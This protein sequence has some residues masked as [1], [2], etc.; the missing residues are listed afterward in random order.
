MNMIARHE[1]WRKEYRGSRY[2]EFLSQEE[3]ETRAKDV[4]C[5]LMILS[6]KGQISLREM[7]RAGE[8]W[9]VIWTHLLEEFVIRYGPYPNG[10]TNGFIKDADVVVPS[11]PQPLRSKVAIDV[12]GGA[13]NGQLYKFSRMEFLEDSYKFGRFRI[14][15]ASAYNDPSLNNAVRDDELSFVVSTRGEKIL[16]NYNNEAMQSYGRVD[17]K[18]TSNTNY[19][20]ACFATNYTYR[21]Y[22]D[23]KANGCL[24]I[25]DARRF[26]A[27]LLEAVSAQL[28]DYRCFASSVRYIDPLNSKPGDVDVF[29]AKH[30]RFSYQNEYRAVWVP[31]TDI[32]VLEPVWVELGSMESYAELISLN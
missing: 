12:I 15:A 2:M 23:F 3:L 4:F 6:P 5:N 1:L 8:Y 16:Y 11:Y 18:L 17:H 7:S 9:I 29:M 30:F 31:N 21:E 27:A 20:V 14:S 13:K 32:S 10:F 26:T 22:D 28:T 25:K 19:Y 24:V